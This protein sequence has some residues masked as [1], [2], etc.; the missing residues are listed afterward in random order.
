M[1]KSTVS[2]VRNS[3]LGG[4]DIGLGQFR[5]AWAE[6]APVPERELAAAVIEG[7]AA[8]LRHYRFA[9]TRDLQRLYCRAHRW[10]ASENREWPFSFVNLC[11]VLRL[12]P[13]AVRAQLLFQRDCQ[14][15]RNPADRHERARAARAA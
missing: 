15:G 2:K 10:V 12:S 11:E 3:L 4:G 1:H 13:E 9:R 7:A 8:D 6:Q 5:D 14:L